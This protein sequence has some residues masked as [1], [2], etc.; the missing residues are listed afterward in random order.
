[1]GS[2]AVLDA[3]M[4]RKIPSPHRKSNPRTPIVYLV[5]KVAVGFLEL[6][7]TTTKVTPE[8]SLLVYCGKT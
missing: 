2:R 4:N 7:L 1:M 6:S 8:K 5:A 3:V